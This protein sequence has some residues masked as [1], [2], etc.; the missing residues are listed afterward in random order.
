MTLNNE[1][2]KASESD[3]KSL[4]V[5][6][7]PGTG[8]T[9]A[10]VARFIHL[11]NQGVKPK[12]I[13]CC[14]FARKAADEIEKRINSEMSLDKKDLSIGTFHSIGNK[15][16]KELGHLVGI[17]IPEKILSWDKDRLK[18]IK[19]LQ[20]ELE[21]EY[22]LIDDKEEKSP[23]A[24]L[25]Y[26]DNV[27]KKL[28][29]PEDAGVEAAQNGNKA[30]MAHAGVYDLYEK[31]LTEN[32]LID[33]ERMIQWSCRVLEADASSNQDFISQFTHILVDEYQDINFAQKTMIDYFLKSG[34][35]LWVVGDDDQAIY[36]WR[37]S[38]VDFILDFEKNYPG[39]SKVYLSK[40]YRSGSKIVNVAN[41]LAQRF[42][43]RHDKNINSERD[44]K[45]NVEIINLKTEEF[46][47]LEI[48]SSVKE[49]H[50]QGIEYKDIAVLARTN[51]L[52][53]TIISKLIS[54]G[55]PVAVRHGVKL[56]KDPVPQDLLT[57]VAVSS[58][59]KPEK[60]WNKNISPNVVSFAKKISH[61]PW[62]TQVKALAT[63]LE[64]WSPKYLNDDELI[65]RIDILTNYR[66]YLLEFK[67]ANDVF[68][69]IRNAQIISESKNSVHVGTIHGSKGLEWDTVYV[70][71]WEDNLMPHELNSYLKSKIDEERRLAYVAI[72]RAKNL[73]KLFYLD[74]RSK[75]SQPPSRFLAE[76][77]QKKDIEKFD[78]SPEKREVYNVNENDDKE[79]KEDN[80]DYEEFQ[81][82]FNE[83]QEKR[84]THNKNTIS[85]NIA[86]GMKQ[87][88]QQLFIA[89]EGLLSLAGYNVQKNGP[90]QRERQN[91]LAKIFHGE[92]E[93]PSTFSEN[94]SEQWGSPNSTERLRKIRNTINTSLGMQKGRSNTS[95][96][97]VKKWEEDLEYIDDELKPE[98]EA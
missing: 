7:G 95:L 49:R 31:Y 68:P 93:L 21:D 23:L 16:I 38:S 6:A 3:A 64:K 88:S 29:D 97:A 84:K 48:V 39:S 44:T 75:K 54:A 80:E 53:T 13:L 72:T 10:L 65:Q 82:I 32:K 91:L 22:N 43:K 1:Q 83:L 30:N 26:I 18:I 92:V 81:K 40:N 76:I 73:L 60:G 11:V 78:H 90:L 56:F 45:G 17:Q 34:S 37:G 14:A 74:E 41:R 8:K 46:E 63:L 85:E 35:N 69:R 20:K 52:P 98:I 62:K 42:Y 96:Q 27:R 89:G 5:L 57:A 33:F 77:Y 59:T 55:I 12:N 58:N 51:F 15:A 47:A 24:V 2:K 71:G 36:G 28:L 79:D 67:N 94:L 87:G 66:D 9:T 86:D 61:E 70:I 25:Q 19:E 50:K 4:L